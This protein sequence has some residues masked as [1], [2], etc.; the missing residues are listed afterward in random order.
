M[1]EIAVLFFLALVWVIFAT[2]SDIKS[3]EIPNWLN[4]SLAIFALSLRFF[5]SFFSGDGSGF[6][7]AIL[8]LGFSIL[9]FIS[10]FNSSFKKRY[11]EVLYFFA[12]SAFFAG[13]IWLYL[14][15]PA[16]LSGSSFSFFYQGIIGLGIFFVIGNLLSYGRAFAGGDTKLMVALGAVLP[17]FFNTLLNITILLLFTL[18]FLVSGSFYG[19]FASAYIGLSNLDKLKKSFIKSFADHK[20]LVF[21]YCLAGIIFLIF[22]VINPSFGYFGVF[23]FVFPYFYL[24]LKSVDESCMIK[25]VKVSELTPGDWLYKDVKIGRK[26]IKATWDGLSKEDILSMKSRKSVLIRRGIAFAPVFLISMVLLIVFYLTGFFG[27][28]FNLLWF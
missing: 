24:F 3:K 9:L 1:I 11:K 8:I 23:L 5:Y 21:G 13:V 6:F 4:F 10:F 28:F 19:L 25:N 12:V 17:L 16:I 2:I 14:S 22:G 20:K 7:P 27:Y 15:D 26:T 18:I